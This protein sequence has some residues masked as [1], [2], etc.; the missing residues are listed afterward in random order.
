MKQFDDGMNMMRNKWPQGKGMAYFQAYTNT[1]ASLDRLKEIYEP[2]INKVGIFAGNT[3]GSC[4]LS[5][6]LGINVV[7]VTS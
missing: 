3:V 4:N 2:F 1:Y 6:K 7:F 5:S